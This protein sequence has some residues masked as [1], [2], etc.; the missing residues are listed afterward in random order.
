M[1]GSSSATAWGVAHDVGTS[2]WLLPLRESAT[3]RKKDALARLADAAAARGH[4][5]TSQKGGP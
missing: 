5:K 3:P 1:V 4:R 2:G